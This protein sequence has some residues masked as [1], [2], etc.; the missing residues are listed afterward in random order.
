MN[1]GIQIV[2]RLAVIEICLILTVE[3]KELENMKN[4]QWREECIQMDIESE[5]PF[6]IF[7]QWIGTEEF[8]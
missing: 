1:T 8:I 2:V 4:D 7:L 6:D 3:E 5:S